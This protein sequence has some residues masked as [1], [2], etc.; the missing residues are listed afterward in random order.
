MVCYQGVTVVL[1]L[2]TKTVEMCAFSV[3][4]DPLQTPHQKSILQNFWCQ[5]NCSPPLQKKGG[6]AEISETPFFRLTILENSPFWGIYFLKTSFF[7]GQAVRCPPP[8]IAGRG[9]LIIN[10]GSLISRSLKIIN[11]LNINTHIEK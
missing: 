1:G 6:S 8:T 3:I 2:F 11:V 5:Y 9:T 7:L 4:D 10:E